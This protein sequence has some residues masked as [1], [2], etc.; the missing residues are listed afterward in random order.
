MQINVTRSPRSSAE[1]CKIQQ[2]IQTCI[3]CLSQKRMKSETNC[4]RGQLTFTYRNLIIPRAIIACDRHS[5]DNLVS[6]TAEKIYQVSMPKIF[7]PF[8]ARRWSCRFITWCYGGQEKKF[9]LKCYQLKKRKELKW[10]QGLTRKPSS[11]QS[12]QATINYL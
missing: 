9:L 6:L 1:T 11:A 5:T 12:L 2:I 10:C 4:S 7:T 3:F 8:P